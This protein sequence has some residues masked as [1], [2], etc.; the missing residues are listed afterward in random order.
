MKKNLIMLFLVVLLSACS[1]AGPSSESTGSQPAEGTDTAALEQLQ[2]DNA[3]LQE[4][5]EQS[6]EAD[7]AVD[8]VLRETLNMTFRLI[9]AMDDKDYDYIASVSSS[10]VEV[11]QDKNMLIVRNEQAEAPT[12]VALLSGL[13]LA[14]LEFRGFE[15][16]D[17]SH[18][19]LFMA[20]VS[21][22]EGSE[23]NAALNFQFVRSGG[24]AWQFDGLL[25]N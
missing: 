9:T 18:A 24:G 12:E 14:E 19:V 8:G 15:Q 21:T 7:K 22:T 10:N 6:K 25:T 20:R 13:G 11:S 17:E 16:T 4:Q 2:Q 1:N 23:G 5:L 3:K